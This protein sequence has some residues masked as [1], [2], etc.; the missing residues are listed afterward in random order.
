MGGAAKTRE[1]PLEPFYQGPADEGGFPEGAPVD[2]NEFVFEFEVRGDEVE[3]GNIGCLRIRS[4]L[5]HFP[6]SLIIS[7]G[8]RLLCCL[9]GHRGLPCSRRQRWSFRR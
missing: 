4:C 5:I 2:L 8:F 1:L 3:K 9:P 6:C 7:P